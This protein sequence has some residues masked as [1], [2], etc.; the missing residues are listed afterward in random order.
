MK[1]LRSFGHRGRVAIKADNEP[2]ILAL[3]EEI[4]RR[5][6]VGAIPVESVPVIRKTTAPMKLV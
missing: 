4:M 3:K 6:E 1:G 2:A 5:P